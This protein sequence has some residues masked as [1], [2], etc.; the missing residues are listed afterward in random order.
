MPYRFLNLLAVELWFSG[1]F[2][3]VGGMKIFLS[4]LGGKK[5]ILPNQGEFAV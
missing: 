1:L 5:N 4:E 3:K 2:I